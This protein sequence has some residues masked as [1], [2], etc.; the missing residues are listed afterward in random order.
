MH[1]RLRDVKSSQARQQMRS[2][3]ERG[4]RQAKDSEFGLIEIIDFRS[5]FETAVRD[6]RLTDS[7]ARSLRDAYDRMAD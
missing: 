4:M 3:V 7:E 1:E 6:N 5:R 2:L